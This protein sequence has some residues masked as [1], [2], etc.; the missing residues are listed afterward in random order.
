MAPPYVTYWKVWH[1]KKGKLVFS[2]RPEWETL[3][4]RQSHWA[5]ELIMLEWVKVSSGEL[6]G[7]SIGLGYIQG[8]VGGG[9]NGSMVGGSLWGAS[10]KRRA[11]LR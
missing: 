1:L 3:S 10:G 11:Q 8:T 9:F 7:V 5:G 6:G 2:R 4:Q